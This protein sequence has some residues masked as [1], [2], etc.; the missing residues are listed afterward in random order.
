ME[1]TKL[2]PKEQGGEGGAREGGRIVAW[3]STH[4]DVY[5][6]T[7]TTS[8]VPLVGAEG[9]RTPIPC[10]DDDDAPSRPLALKIRIWR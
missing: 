5:P 2:G 9:R 6:S 10:A 1:G 4:A 3:D 8:L 7:T